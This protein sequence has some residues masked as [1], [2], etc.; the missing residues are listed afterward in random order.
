MFLGGI[1]FV[2]L[3]ISPAEVCLEA[4][5]LL[6]AAKVERTAAAIADERV[7]NRA[8][9]IIRAHDALADSGS[10]SLEGAFLEG[11]QVNRGKVHVLSR[12]LS[13]GSCQKREKRNESESD[14]HFE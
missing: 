5:A 2:A 12:G 7:A 11:G 14:L 6:G 4:A 10:G 3:P 8:Q 9:V 13:S 1:I